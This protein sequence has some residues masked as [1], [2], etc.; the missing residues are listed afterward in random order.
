MLSSS[1]LVNLVIAPL[2]RDAASKC[3]QHLM[4]YQSGCTCDL[5]TP[6]QFYAEPPLFPCD[7]HILRDT[8]NS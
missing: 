6:S 1:D 2:L 5:K 3:Y 7:L 8:D 4:Q